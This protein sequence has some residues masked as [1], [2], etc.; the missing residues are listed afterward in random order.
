[1]KAIQTVVG[2]YKFVNFFV[3]WTMEIKWQQQ[4]SDTDKPCHKQE[5]NILSWRQA[6]LRSCDG[7]YN[8]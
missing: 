1:M 4:T 2:G 3:S 5:N 6:S 7:V 8:K